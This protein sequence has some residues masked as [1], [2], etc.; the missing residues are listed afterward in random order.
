MNLSCI[1]LLMATTVVDSAVRSTA[2]EEPVVVASLTSTKST[3]SGTTDETVGN[4]ND[5]GRSV[6]QKLALSA[7][8][9][10]KITN[11]WK[12]AKRYRSLGH[13]YWMLE[14]AGFPV[15]DEEENV[16]EK[17]VVQFFL[18]QSFK[19]WFKYARASHKE[20]EWI[21]FLEVIYTQ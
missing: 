2:S 19:F 18:S 4:T 6:V 8:D 9:I 15:Q 1:L 11:L 3:K 13:T 20:A 7:L 5:E 17:L 21:A 10:A 12:P 16:I 14:L